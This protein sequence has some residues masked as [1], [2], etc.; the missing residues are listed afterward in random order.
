M[1]E[2]F[3]R[4]NPYLGPVKA[5]ILDWT[6]TAVDFGSFGK[7]QPFIE[8]MQQHW[9]EITAEDVR[10]YMGLAPWD[11]LAAIV[12]DEGV[13]SRW[14]DVYGEAPSEYDLDRIFRSIEALMPQSAA[15]HS[16][17]VPG[18]LETVS[19]LRNRDI[20]IGSTSSF[21]FQAMEALSG[22]ARE[23]GYAPD[24]SVCSTDVPGGRP[25]PWMC[26]RNAE[27][28]EVYPMSAIVK[29][30]DTIPDMEEGLNAGMWTVGVTKTGNYLG[31]SREEVS[32]ADEVELRNRI[33][34]IGKRFMDAGA[35]FVVEGVWDC[36]A[37]IE[38]INLLLA[39]G[40]KP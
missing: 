39:A 26:H 6:G 8:G 3:S 33:D 36:P 21:T 37:V 40:E 5:V 12:N 18:L 27:N 32:A 19:E 25:Y 22:A 23:K 16:D 20:R 10:K 31:M 29:V 14:L 13:L 9:V 7:I 38:Q 35:R 15:M 17:P 11:Q 24:S 4:K 30:G 28:L 2:V 34:L 1:A